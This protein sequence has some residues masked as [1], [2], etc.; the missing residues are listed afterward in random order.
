MMDSFTWEPVF[1]DVSR[2]GDLGYTIGE[3]L[4]TS[5]DSAGNEISGRGYYV[6]IWKK[7]INGWQR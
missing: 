6:T 1:A 7:Q 4:F 3:Y 5:L 2:A